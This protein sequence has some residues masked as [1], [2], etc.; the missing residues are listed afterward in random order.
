M[1]PARSSRA[2]RT[3]FAAA[4]A[5]AALACSKRAQPRRLPPTPSPRAPAP[6]ALRPSAEVL[7]AAVL[8]TIREAGNAARGK[9]L[10]RKFEC[11]RCHDG[12]GLGAAPLEKSCVHCHQQIA[13]GVYPAPAKVLAQWRKHTAIM[14][15]VPSL[16]GERRLRREWIVRFLLAPFD[17]RPEL[18][19]SMPRFALKPAQ[20][21]DIAAYLTRSSAPQA[22]LSLRSANPKHGRT[23]I[24]QN[25]CGACHHFSGVTTLNASPPS[26]AGLASPAIALAPDLRYVRDRYTPASLVAWLRDPKSVKPDALMPT[27]GFS[28]A[29]AR[30]IAAYLLTVKL[31]P[32]VKAAIPERLPL[33]RRRVTFDEV[34][35]RVF[36]QTCHHC[37]G[38][39]DL[40]LG[41]GGPGNSGGFGFFARGL[42]LSSYRG[43]SG[44]LLDA[45]GERHSVFAPTSDGTPLLVAVLVARQREQAGR[46]DPELRGMPLGLPALS[47]ADVQLVA[48]WVAEGRPR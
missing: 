35:R 7:P 44:G 46:V 48:T 23:L 10:V 12:T 28:R 36:G 27:F 18:E 42:D 2:A 17:L 32:P 33:L 15:V 24:E 14:Q 45:R 3:I 16:T 11:N 29:A 6:K 4:F 41:Y 20:A 47:P 40:T 26:G 1:D 22:T 5:F 37:H 30:D 25:G 8:T 9:E 13:T 19:P 34:N 43:V 39:P 38:N 21:R 31:A